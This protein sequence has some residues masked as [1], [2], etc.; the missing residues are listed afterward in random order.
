MALN[1]N[2]LNQQ[3]S[4]LGDTLGV[5]AATQRDR[6][7]LAR[8]RLEQFSEEYELLRGKVERT[9]SHGRR[10]ELGWVGAF[11]PPDDADCRPLARGYDLPP[12]PPQA[13]LIAD[14]G[15]Q[16]LPDR[17]AVLP[18][19]LIS[20]GAIVLRQGSGQAP[21]VEVTQDLHYADD[22]LY[23]EDGEIVAGRE[24]NALRDLRAIQ[25]LA[26]LAG[27]H[28]EPPALAI[29]D[30]P[31]L[32]WGYQETQ[33]GAQRKKD[34]N[35]R[36]YLHALSQIQHAGAYAA[37]YI[38]RP[39]NRGL[40]NLLY[41]A[42]LDDEA[43]SQA[44]LKQF[45]LAG[46]RDRDV[47]ARLLEPGQ[48]SALLITQSHINK[49]YTDKGHE[50]WF[51]Y[52]NVAGRRAGGEPERAAIARVEVPVWVAQDA[53]AL[54]TVHALLYRQCQVLAA[55]RY[56]YVLARADELARIDPGDKHEVERLVQRVMMQ[57]G[58][59]ALPSQKEQAKQLTR[60]RKR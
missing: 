26:R 35:I 45:D 4:Q 30:G 14:D 6:L 59:P 41:L 10:R 47:F 18:Y 8:R 54:D 9:R 40:V 33:P 24:V 44:T 25:E 20:V 37:G 19:Y 29:V 53:A 16:I 52:L 3:V 2:Q 13:T 48:R 34:E 39:E 60:G 56:P 58:L 49:T 1:L 11:P 55:P 31:L 27:L 57:R 43:I 32:L 17:H 46:V 12:C 21:Q 51:F 7:A 5:R 22:D 15:S 50:V 23:N 28:R 36:A 42:T 38:D